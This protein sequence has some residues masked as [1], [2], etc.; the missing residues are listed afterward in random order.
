MISY[1]K[2]NEEYKYHSDRATMTALWW[3]Y[4]EPKGFTGGDLSFKDNDIKINCKN[5]RRIC[6]IFIYTHLVK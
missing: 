3:T 4:K 6:Q 1:Y 5:I 2:N